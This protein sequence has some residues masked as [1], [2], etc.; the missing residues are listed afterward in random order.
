MF[1]LD[2]MSYVHGVSMVRQ[3][4]AD[5]HSSCGGS[6]APG[7]GL[8][9]TPENKSDLLLQEIPTDIRK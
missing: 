9:G 5:D 3:R 2:R 6:L 4:P 7:V 8:E 1:I